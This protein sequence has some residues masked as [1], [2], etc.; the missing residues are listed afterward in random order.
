MTLAELK[1]Q[2]GKPYER[3]DEKGLA[4]G[5]MAPV[6]ALYPDV[7]RYDWP[8]DE[9]T[10]GEYL[11]DRFP[12]HAALIDIADMLPGDIILA[13]LPFGLVHPG[14]YLGGGNMLHCL[15]DTGWEI[16]R[17]SGVRIKGVYRPCRQAD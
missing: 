2:V 13:Q 7:P 1:M 16:M 6:F 14:I 3:Y 17:Y 8:V 11:N 10:I 5:C 4:S 12:R 15:R 9:S